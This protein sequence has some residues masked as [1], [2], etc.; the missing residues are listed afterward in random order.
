MSDESVTHNNLEAPVLERQLGRITENETPV[1]IESTNIGARDID[2]GERDIRP[3][4]LKPLLEE[5]SCHS[6]GSAG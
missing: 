3:E 4:G 5:Y 1:T 2:H 6:P